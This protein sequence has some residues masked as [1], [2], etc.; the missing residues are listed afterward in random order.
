MQGRRIFK[1]AAEHVPGVAEAACKAAG[2]SLGDIDVFVPHQANHRITEAL[3]KTLDLGDTV[4]VAD[5][6][7]QAGNT[8]AASIPLAVHRLLAQGRARSGDVAL[9]VG[10]GGGLAYAGQVVT[11]P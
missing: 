2:V 5:D 6:I 9:L 4:V 1:W 10:F 3:V 8:S 11:L 7:I